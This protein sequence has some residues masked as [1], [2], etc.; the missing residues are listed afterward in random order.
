MDT[1]LHTTLNESKKRERE[2][3]PE[4][5][6]YIRLCYITRFRSPRF[7][8][9]FFTRSNQII[10]IDI[11]LLP[12]WLC[13]LDSINLTKGLHRRESYALRCVASTGRDKI[14]LKNIKRIVGRF[15]RA[16]DCIKSARGKFFGELYT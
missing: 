5:I 10:S 13:Q 3:I 4:V 15:S 6:F 1:V 9:S 7:L 2:V 8:V 16:D 12:R 11:L 14:Q